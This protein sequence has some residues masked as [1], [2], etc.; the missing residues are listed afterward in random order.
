MQQATYDAV[1]I[2]AG[3]AGSTAAFVLASSGLRVALIDRRNFPRPKL[4]GGLLTWKT[5]QFLEAVFQVSP[6]MLAAHGIIHH[7]AYAY[8]VGGGG[9]H[10]LCR[11]L[12]DPFHLV[13]RQA[14]D[15]FWLNRAVAAG[16]EFH[17]G[18]AVVTLDLKRCEATTRTGQKWIGRF[19]IGADGVHS[20]VRRALLH[21]RRIAAPR[22]PGLATALECVVPRPSEAVPDHPAIFYGL[23]PWGYAWSFPGATEWVLGMAALKPKSGFQIR[24]GFRAF[25]K[26]VG[27]TDPSH[28]RIHAHALPYGNYLKTPGWSKILLTG[29]AAGLADPFL[30]EGIYYAHRS[31][32]LAAQAIAE[33]R[34]QP[35]S[36]VDRYCETY[37]RTIHPELRYARAGRQIL[38]S[39]PPRL[40]F[41]LLTVFLR[42]FPKTCEET[43]QGRR[44]F[45][46]FRRLSPPS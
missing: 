28:L 44:S 17:A 34:A 5:I 13:D 18:S 11:K 42:L 45:K 27:I 40:Y 4:C 36:A 31:A 26:H 23:I 3:P 6:Q 43:V 22:Y 29:D 21:T 8:T 30:G 12:D 32:Q 1:I 7:V 19:L 9:R 41:P 10:G 46:W 15:D 25:L 39:L 33:C 24:A 35:A 37:R 16:A 2:G 38:F 14:Y 20:R